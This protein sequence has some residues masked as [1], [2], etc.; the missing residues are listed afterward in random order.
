M[1]KVTNRNLSPFEKETI[2]NFNKGEEEASIFTYEKTWQKHLETRFNIK[3]VLVNNYGGKSY[4]INKNRIM[5]PRA[6][7]SKKKKVARKDLIK[8]E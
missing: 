1:K 2:I 5:K 4:I 8:K 7:L 6:P 3:P